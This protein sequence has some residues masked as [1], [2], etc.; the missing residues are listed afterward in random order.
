MGRE[1]GEELEKRFGG[2]YNGI[3]QTFR[4]GEGKRIKGTVSIVSAGSSDRRVV[5]EAKETLVFLGASFRTFEDIGIA[6]VHRLFNFIDEIGESTVSIV[7]AGMEGALPSLVS[8]L[9]KVPV[10]GVPTSTGYGT[11]FFGITPLLSMLNSCSPGVA[12]VNIDSGFGAACFAYKILL[13]LD[14]CTS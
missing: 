14:R 7:V 11:N 9:T 8:S 2:S 1:L 6:G 4:V 10:I 5:E 12:V 3:S 13:S